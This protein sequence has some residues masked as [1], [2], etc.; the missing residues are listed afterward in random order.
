MAL[1]VSLIN[2]PSGRNLQTVKMETTSQQAINAPKGFRNILADGPCERRI[3]R[4]DMLTHCR[5]VAC[6]RDFRQQTTRAW[7]NIRRINCQKTYH[8]RS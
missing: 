7:F 4:W 1:V 8:T 3:A 5:C 6:G 2:S